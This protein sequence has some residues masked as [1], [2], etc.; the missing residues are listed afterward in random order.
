FRL[1]GI[2]RLIGV[3]LSQALQQKIFHEK[4][5][6]F[7]H[8]SE[9]LARSLAP[10]G[11]LRLEHRSSWDLV[12]SSAERARAQLE[13]R[14][15]HACPG[16]LSISIGTKIDVKDWG[17]DNWRALLEDLSNRLPLWGLAA[18]GASVEYGR[19]SAL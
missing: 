8:R 4:S 2:R 11:D 12:F 17:D 18:I 14:P 7:E 6:R 10:L 3:P 16:I 1:L 9:Y 19:S 5:G 15:L 13:L